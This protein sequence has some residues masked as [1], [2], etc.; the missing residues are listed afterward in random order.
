[1]AVRRVM[2]AAMSMPPRKGPAAPP[3]REIVFPILRPAEQFV[4]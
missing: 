2:V 1:M 4:D 3:Q